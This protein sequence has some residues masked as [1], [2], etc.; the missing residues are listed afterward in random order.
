MS[1]VLHIDPFGGVAGDMLLGAL[2][3][4][5][6]ARGGVFEVLEGLGI[7][8]WRLECETTRHQGL[9]GTRVKVLIDEE[10]HPA[11]HLAD[12]Q[13]LLRQAELP[14][15]VRERSLT[16]FEAIF[17]AEAKVHGVAIEKTHLHELAA[18]DALVDIVGTC[19]AVDLIGADAVTCGPVPVGRGTVQTAHGVLPVPPP[20]VAQLLEGFPLAAHG[21]DGEMTTPTGAALVRVLATRFGSLPAGRLEGSGVGLGTRVFPGMPN[22]LRVFLVDTGDE[23]GHDREL[24]LIECT[25]DDVTG[26][27]LG[28]LIERLVTA[29]ALDAWAVPGTGRKG[30]PNYELRAVADPTATGDVVAELFR[31]GGS[32]GVRV[33]AC[34]RPEIERRIVMVA[35]L[36]GQVPVKLGL[37]AGVVVSAKPE[38]E[39]CR[40]AAEQH[41]VPI[42]SVED[43]ARRAAPP[44][45][46]R[47]DLGK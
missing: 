35:T 39:A 18:V 3:D 22:V 25:V 17:A 47:T 44:I 13:R 4:L 40:A 24:A 34:R 21:A 27:R 30:R 12:V 14:E 41:R 19:A 9:A 7:G 16:V 29:G 33:L 31:Q 11:R 1:R 36:Y 5:G 6:A 2:I 32:L 23:G 8:G 42:A 37:H 46:D 10:S 28:Y 43:A 15:S 45:G 20:A 38:F 26:E